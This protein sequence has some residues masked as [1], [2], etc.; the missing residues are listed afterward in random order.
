MGE[1]DIGRARHERP[2]QARLYFI[3]VA[4]GV[5]PLVRPVRGYGARPSIDVNEETEA[6]WRTQLRAFASA[7]CPQ[8]VLV[9]SGRRRRIARG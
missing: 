5:P 9:E 8:V 6:G 2:A 3:V 1:V 7:V 4:C